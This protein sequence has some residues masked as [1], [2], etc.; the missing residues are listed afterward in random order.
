MTMGTEL[1]ELAIHINAIA[2]VRAELATAIEQG[3]PQYEI[4]AIFK[5]LNS[6]HVCLYSAAKRTVIAYQEAA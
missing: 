5:R 4:D 1:K 2:K 6:L 3:L